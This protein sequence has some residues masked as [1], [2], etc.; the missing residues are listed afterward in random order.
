MVATMEG[1][2]PTRELAASPP[3]PS[4]GDPRPPCHLRATSDGHVRYRADNH[5]QLHAADE[6]VAS[7]LAA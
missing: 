3:G 6:L 1:P 4:H 2:R 7:L 5:G